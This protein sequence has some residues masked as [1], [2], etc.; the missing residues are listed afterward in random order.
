MLQHQETENLF[1]YSAVVVDNDTNKTAQSLVEDLQKTSTIRIDYFNEPEQNIALAR[2]KAVENAHG[3]YIAFIDDDEFP[4]SNWL[5][6]LYKSITIY[7]ADGVLGPVRPHYPAS[8]PTWLIKSKLC[9]RPEHQTGTVLNWGDTRTGN[10]LFDSKIFRDQNNRFGP[11]YGRTGGEDIEFF[12]IMV[13]SGRIFIWCNEAPAYETISKERWSKKFYE[14]RS[15]RI[16]G[17]VGEK[18]RQRAQISQRSYSLIKSVVWIAAMTIIT[19]FA[20]I[21]GDHLYLRAVTKIMY[22]KGLLL[23]FMGRAVIRNR[24]E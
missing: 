2:N 13:E 24:D 7:K 4:I 5:L 1:T 16:G 14:Q 17:L 20:K 8:C 19:P 6:N 11:E 12:K 18:I 15:L 23:G 10:V 21:V 9:E 3:N 22:N